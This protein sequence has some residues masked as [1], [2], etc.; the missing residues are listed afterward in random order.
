MCCYGITT[1]NC[2]NDF[3]LVNN[4]RAGKSIR[5]S[6][7]LDFDKVCLAAYSWSNENLPITY[8]SELPPCMVAVDYTGFTYTDT[9]FL[10][11]DRLAY[12]NETYN[13]PQKVWNF[14][15]VSPFISSSNI[16]LIEVS[17][18]GQFSATSRPRCSLFW[19]SDS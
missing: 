4:W 8:V 7:A 16:L 2:D 9:I 11:S 19:T 1:A 14:M 13:C 5:N 15:S 12:T 18:K 6:T 3:R 10:Y 17:A